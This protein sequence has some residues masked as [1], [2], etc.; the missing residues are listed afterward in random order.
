MQLTFWKELYPELSSHPTLRP[1]EPRARGSTN[2]SIGRSGVRINALLNS[3]SARIEVKL[4][5]TD[6]NAPVYFQEL[7]SAK[8]DIESDLGFAPDWLPLP[9]KKVSRISIYKDSCPLDEK[10]R[11]PEY[12]AWFISHLEDFERVFRPRVKALNRDDFDSEQDSEQDEAE[13]V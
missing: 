1:S 6:E 5:M 7:E 2:L 10:D 8:A 3:Q 9:N 12:R 4:E 13:A 11:W